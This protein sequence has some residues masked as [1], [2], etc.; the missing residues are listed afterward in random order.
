[1]GAQ[2]NK[3]NSIAM[4]EALQQKKPAGFLAGLADDAVVT[5][6]GCQELLPWTVQVK[7]KNNFPGWTMAMNEHIS[8][9]KVELKN[10]VADGNTVVI[11]LHEWLT[12]QHNKFSFELDEV[13][14][15]TYN[16]EGKVIDISM[17]E[18]TAAV[19]AAV[20]GKRVEEL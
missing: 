6:P 10:F 16:D 15:H 7:G 2:E 11:F 14:V 3:K 9:D 20:R 8:I 13:H 17:Y 1:M 19:V 5:A 4:Y 18:D 12:V